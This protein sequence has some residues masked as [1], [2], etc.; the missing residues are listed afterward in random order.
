MLRHPGLRVG[1]GAHT[2]K[3]AEK[4]GRWVRKLVLRG[5]GERG[6][7]NRVDEWNLTNGSTFIAKGMGAAIAGE[8]L[9][10]FCIDDIFGSR[11]DAD[12]PTKQE[13]AYEWYM[14]DVTPR[15]QKDAAL[16]MVNTRWNPGDL[17]GRI[18]QS[19]EWKEWVYVRI[20]AISETQEE[21]DEVNVA[22][23]IPKGLPDPLNREPGVALC[24][25]RFP[26][27]KLRQKQ[28]IEGV[29]FAS[30]YQGHPIPRGGTFFERNWFEI[31]TQLPNEKPIRLVRYFDLASSRLDSACYTA[32][33]LMAKVGLAEKTMYVILDVIR[34]RWMPAERNTMMLNTAIADESRAGFERT[35][36]EEPVYDKDKAAMRGIMAKLAGRRVSPHNV[37]GAGSKELRAEPVADAAKAGLIKVLAG[38]NAG[39]WIPTFLNEIEGFPKGQYKD[40]TD[41]LSGAFAKL[42]VGETIIRM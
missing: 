33:V 38:P 34:G 36:F 20:P 27:E 17:M 32:G 13:R 10:C 40:Q 35:W 42:S 15:L 19:E 31:I 26:I 22:Q 2:Q 30:L 28:R 21:R 24:P 41:S 11:Q 9:D 8:P 12:S 6:D 7:V 5:G 39:N 4:I 16:L 23:G 25:D 37:S 1:I 14:D 29:G 18:Q 3:Y